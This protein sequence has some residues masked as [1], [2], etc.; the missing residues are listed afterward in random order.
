[1]DV[2]QVLRLEQGS[3]RFGPVAVAL[4]GIDLA[5]V[6]EQPERLCQGP[7]RHRVRGEALVEHADGRAQALV[8]QVVVEARQVHGHHQALVGDDPRRQAADVEIRVVA[9]GDLGAPARHEQGRGQLLLAALATVD[10]QLLD[11]WQRRHGD[12]AADARVHGHGAPAQHVHA[13]CAYRLLQGLAPG[14]AAASSWPRNI[15][16]TARR[17]EAL[18]PNSS[19]ARSR[20]NASGI[21]MSRPHPS[22]VRPSAAMP[23]RCVMQVRDSIATCRRRWLASPD[24]CAMRPKPQLSRNSSGL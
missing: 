1:M 18:K 21:C 13:A 24:M 8:R 15:W 2:G 14:R 3:A 22:P 17:V 20:M 6:G 9:A 16:P 19:A 7:A 4:D 12:I 23:P 10:E 11:A 5:V